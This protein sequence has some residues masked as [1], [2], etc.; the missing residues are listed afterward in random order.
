MVAGSWGISWTN[1]RFE[2]WTAWYKLKVCYQKIIAVMYFLTLTLSI[3]M[4]H[5]KHFWYRTHAYIS[6]FVQLQVIL[7]C[8]T[9]WSMKSGYS[10]SALPCQFLVVTFLSSSRGLFF[11]KASPE[12]LLNFHPFRFSRPAWTKP[13]A[14][15]AELSVDLVLS[16]RLNQVTSEMLPNLVDSVKYF[17]SFWIF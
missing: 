10:R 17:C 6:S 4:E 11:F 8:L 12:R 14:V 9:F 16:T 15:C 1:P 2:C 5:W 3:K 7:L 13:S